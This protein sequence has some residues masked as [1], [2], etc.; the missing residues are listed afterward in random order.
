MNRMNEHL[1]IQISYNSHGPSSLEYLFP[2]GAF[3]VMS[4]FV[5]LLSTL[6]QY[7]NDVKLV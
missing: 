2:G 5:S 6:S 7:L 4:L 3:H 1:I